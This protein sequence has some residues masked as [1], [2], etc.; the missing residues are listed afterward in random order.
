MQPPDGLSDADFVRAVDTAIRARRTRKVLDGPGRAGRVDSPEEADAFRIALREAIATAGLAPFHYA[1]KEDLP[2]P[3]RFH[4][5]T[6]AALARLTEALTEAEI[7][8]G[9]LPAIFAGAGAMVQVTWLP[10]KQEKRAVRDW[11]HAAAAAAAVQNLL[12]A[13]HARGI[14]SYWCSAPALG[15]ERVAKL[16]DVPRKQRYLG[17]LFFGRPLSPEDEAERGWSGK[18]NARRTSPEAGW[19]RWHED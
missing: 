16:L 9:K 5:Y 17:T 1:R 14:G 15:E 2:E 4:V 10:E 8:Y 12:L 19:M 3:W 7:L 13:A 11:E 6:G 18:M